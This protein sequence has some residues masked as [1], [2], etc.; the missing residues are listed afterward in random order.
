MNFLIAILA[1]YLANSC[2]HSSRFRSLIVFVTGIVGVTLHEL[3]HYLVAKVLGFKVTQV[4]LFRM[5][6]RANPTMGYVMFTRPDSIMASVG[7]VLVSIAPL[8]IGGICLYLGTQLTYVSSLIAQLQ[9]ASLPDY[10]ETLY[11]IAIHSSLFDL[12]CL[13]VLASIT[14]YML[15]STTDIKGALEGSLYVGLAVYLMIILGIT[16]TLSVSKHLFDYLEQLGTL[17]TFGV[18]LSLPI[19][20]FALL[21]KR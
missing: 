16:Y 7:H 4:C 14:L 20:I 12:V 2:I 10:P 17:M 13:F 15:P 19:A 18:I 9:S 11:A 1:I 21:T 8:I 5:P 6:T 3:S